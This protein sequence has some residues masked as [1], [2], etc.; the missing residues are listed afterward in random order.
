MISPSLNTLETHFLP[1]INQNVP[2][3]AN[4]ESQVF[5]LF[6]K[7]LVKDFCPSQSL[8][9]TNT[10]TSFKALLGIGG[11]LGRIPLI[12]LSLDFNKSIPCLGSISAASN[13]ISY[14]S[15]L[16]WASSKMINQITF[17]L[18]AN[19][20]TSTNMVKNCKIISLLTFNILNGF[21][22]QIPYFIL[23][24]DYNPQNA[25]MVTLNAMDVTLPIYS[26]QLLTTQYTAYFGQT[27]LEK[28]LTILR[29]NLSLNLQ[30]NLTRLIEDPNSFSFDEFH[31]DYL[32]IEEKLEALFNKTEIA[33]PTSIN[34]NS[35]KADYYILLSAKVIGILLLSVQM[36]WLA[37]LCK[38]GLEKITSNAGIIGCF[39]VYVT[40]CNL[41]LTHFV[42][43]GSSLQAIN[44]IKHLFTKKK[45]TYLA[46]SLVN[47]SSVIAKI[48]SI[49]IC[50]SAIIPAAQMSKDYLPNYLYYPSTLLYGLGF[51]FMDYLPLRELLNDAITYYLSKKGTD[52]EKKT[53]AIYS[54]IEELKNIVDN[55]NLKSLARFLLK[56]DQV[57]FFKNLL[58][59]Y[60]LTYDQLFEYASPSPQPL[61]LEIIE[62]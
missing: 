32:S 13:F 24:Y 7:T 21:I 52:E 35:C 58:S 12:P 4:I 45:P 54:Q 43:I 26:L 34:I 9:W 55:S 15:Y 42:L 11:A 17:S 2:C 22:A 20:T 50:A 49:A 19:D 6:K 62:K 14:S 41:A 5:D 48:F 29:S 60:D 16:I 10:A 18:K 37:F 30:Q 51:V 36:A 57:P 28:Q 3:I 61:S 40:I 46:E 56:A 47:K 53:I 1:Q 59:K 31:S 44:G 23:S 8:K 25:Y 27:S 39:C 38:Q 33:T